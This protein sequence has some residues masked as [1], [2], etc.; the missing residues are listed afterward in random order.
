MFGDK[1]KDSV[2]LGPYEIKSDLAIAN[3][4]GRPVY[5]KLDGTDFYINYYEPYNEWGFRS[6]KV[7]GQRTSYAYLR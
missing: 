4:G 2:L 5:Q 1:W 3:T 7:L 6:K